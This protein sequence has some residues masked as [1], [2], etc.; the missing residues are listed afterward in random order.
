MDP[1]KDHGPAGRAVMSA[2]YRDRLTAAEQAL[3]AAILAYPVPA[4]AVRAAGIISDM[5]V[6]PLF[7]RYVRGLI[8]GRPDP[9]AEAAVRL[10][11]PA[12]APQDLAGLVEAVFSARLGY[13]I[14]RVLES[15][16]SAD[17][18]LEGRIMEV[19]GRLRRIFARSGPA[20]A[21]EAM[22]ELAAAPHDRYHLFGLES[23]PVPAGRFALIVAPTNTFKTASAIS[24]A[25][26][27]ARMGMRVLL[28]SMEDSR[29]MVLTRIFLALSRISIVH[30]QR[31]RES[32]ELHRL[33]HEV[34]EQHLDVLSR[35]DILAGDR[36]L[37]MGA[38]HRSAAAGYDLLIID[39]VYRLADAARDIAAAH[40]EL[41]SRIGEML[42][43]IDVPALITN[44]MRS[45]NAMEMWQAL[46]SGRPYDPPPQAV[47][48]GAAY[49]NDAA[50]AAYLIPAFHRS[51]RPSPSETLTFGL[52]P[53]EAWRAF[54]VYVV[55]TKAGGPSRHRAAFIHGEVKVHE[56]PA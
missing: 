30:M 25:L 42:R 53:E 47:M 21:A 40:M 29:A 22:D 33:I 44:Q 46:R 6:D 23:C 20:R 52:N 3:I 1:R 10:M 31:M 17:G 27:A 19:M 14:A 48:G 9:Q 18:L 41:V 56:Q 45:V 11:R 37:S 16:P 5:F 28:V 13:E 50:V 54:W 51:E 38:I 35:I 36:G 12:D 43:D 26:R 15:T 4:L 24:E 39:N 2:A 55:K 49:V 32:G 34:R 8:T 7:E